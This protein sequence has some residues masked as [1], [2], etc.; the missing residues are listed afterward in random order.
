MLVWPETGATGT[1]GYLM[2]ELM[3]RSP[4][5]SDMH[6]LPVRE[7]VVDAIGERL[8]GFDWCDLR[9][10]V[11]TPVAV[12]RR[13]PRLREL[14]IYGQQF[15]WEEYLE[16]EWFQRLHS[17]G[18]MLFQGVTVTDHAI[19][20]LDR[21]PH[22]RFFEVHRFRFEP[23]VVAVADEEGDERLLQA[24]QQRITSGELIFGRIRDRFASRLSFADARR[25]YQR[26][27]RSWTAEGLA[28]GG[29]QA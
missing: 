11:L 13:L 21:L 6:L 3:K 10:N 24:M 2:C 22:L 9:P 27:K 7:D 5:L 19:T 12:L 16:E 4:L 15:F 1:C 17:L 20:T 8:T 26:Q 29:Q 28:E 18:I 25:E 23:N 14:R